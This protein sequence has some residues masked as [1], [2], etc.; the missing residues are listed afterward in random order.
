MKKWRK[1]FLL[2][3]LICFVFLI[4]D[5][6]NYWTS[7]QVLTEE[8]TAYRHQKI[9]L[10]WNAF[11]GADPFFL[12]RDQ[13]SLNGTCFLTTDRRFI[14]LADVVAFHSRDMN[15]LPHPMYRKQHQIYLFWTMEARE[16]VG[17]FKFS[18]DYFN[19][20]MSFSTHSDI[21][22]TYGGIEF[23]KKPAFDGTSSRTLQPTKNYPLPSFDSFVNKTK[24]IF[25]LVS[26]CP[27]LGDDRRWE[28]IE[29][30]QKEYP[31]DMFG[32]CGR[33]RQFKNFCAKGRP[34][35][36]EVVKKE[37]EKRLFHF[38]FENSDC[39]GYVTE[40]TY[41]RI[42]YDSIPI[43]L[44]RAVYEEVD[45]PTSA[46]I[47]VDDFSK[48]KDFVAHLRYLE[49]NETAYKEYFRWRDEYIAVE[50]AEN[51]CELCERISSPDP[52]INFKERKMISKIY[53]EYAWCFQRPVWD[54]PYF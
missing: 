51:W 12:R 25:G 40:K 49:S 38:V 34:D 42:G 47:F 46:F 24:S 44:R 18:R 35:C 8:T 3:L 19:R 9:I 22:L 11:F 10:A 50:K 31:V 20:T 17:Y 33:K 7:E 13:C 41:R 29:K 26:N 48:P 30:I 28:I 53:D 36:D 43:G 15:D 23:V 2:L 1:P 16:N 37:I 52:K 21:R 27:Y 5:N 32:S 6:D 45:L 54:F 39:F 14:R 4:V